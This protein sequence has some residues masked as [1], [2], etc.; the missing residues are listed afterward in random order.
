MTY[1]IVR[2]AIG[3][4]RVVLRVSGRLTGGDVNTLR[5]L[6]E[7]ESDALTLDLKDLLLVDDE[8]VKL[9]AIHESR[10]VTIENCPLYVREWIRREREGT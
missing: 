2:Q 5:T 4:G 7:Q 9:L 8:A 10:G 3:Q 1:K 6:L